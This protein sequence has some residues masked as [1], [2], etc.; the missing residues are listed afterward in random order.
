MGSREEQPIQGDF[1][2]MFYIVKHHYYIFNSHHSP[3][4]FVG[5]R[6]PFGLCIAPFFQFRANDCFEL[7]QRTCSGIYGFCWQFV[8]IIHHSLGE[9]V[10]PDIK[11]RMLLVYFQ[12]MSPC[13]GSYNL[14]DFSLSTA[15][16]SIPFSVQVGP[17][18]ML[19]QW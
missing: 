8:P 9:E 19:F 7:W 18:A 12:I 4:K 1:G 3:Y 5:D 2:H 13:L 6:N 14:E 15:Y 16:I 10:F 17:F 11:S